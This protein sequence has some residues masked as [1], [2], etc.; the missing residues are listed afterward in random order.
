MFNA[1]EIRKEMAEQKDRY[2]GGKFDS[3]FKYCSDGEALK[4]IFVD[5]K[6]RFT[7]PRVLNDPLEFNPTMRFN[8]PDTSYQY[9][10]LNG[11][12]FPSIEFFFRVQI[13]ESQINAYGI[14]PLTKIPNSFDMWSHYANGHKG[15][16]LEFKEDFWHFPCMKS[17]KRDERSFGEVEYVEDYAIN[18]DDLV[19]SKNEIPVDVL[20]RELFFKKTSR[21]SHEREYRLVRPLTDSTDYK[22]P[23]SRYVYTDINVYLFPFEWECISSVIL[24]AAMTTANKKV[25][26]ECCEKHNIPIFQACIIRDQKD[27]FEKPASIYLLSLDQYESKSHASNIKPQV[28]C[29]DTIK[30]GSEKIVKIAKITDLPY[31][32]DYEEIVEELHRNLKKGGDA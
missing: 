14:L 13:I 27:W 25:I 6:I 4:S 2:A 21:W 23:E 7:Q 15:F 29:T 31:Y 8:Q 10:D 18:L 28:L 9:Y 20:H 12:L 22:P 32:R 11:L 16:V 17:E 1:E 19:D 26:V 3:Y 5:R 24:G 30:L